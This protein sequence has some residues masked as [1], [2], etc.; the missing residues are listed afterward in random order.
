[1]SRWTR[2]LTL[3][4]P[5]LIILLLV[6]G[7]AA[8]VLLSATTAHLSSPMIVASLGA[9]LVVVLASFAR[10]TYNGL[11]FLAFALASTVF[12][13][14]DPTDLLLVLLL[15]T[16]I[17]LGQVRLSNSQ[18]TGPFNLLVSIFVF[19]YLV[20]VLAGSAVLGEVDLRFVANLVVK[21]VTLYLLKMYIDSPTRSR[22]VLFGYATA[23]LIVS[24]LAWVASQGWLAWSPALPTP[25]TRFQALLADP[26]VFGSF[27]VP[28]FLLLFDDLVKP[29]V[30]RSTALKFLLLAVFEFSIVFSGSR[31]AWLNTGVALCIYALL[32]ARRFRLQRLVFAGLVVI[33]VGLLSLNAPNL[34]G[35]LASPSARVG[36]MPYDVERFHYQA[37]GLEM[38]LGAFFGVG[39]GQGAAVMG[40]APHNFFVQLILE[41]GV[42]TFA[43]MVAL[44]AYSLG[45]LLHRVALRRDNSLGPSYEALIASLCGLIANGLFIDILYWRVLWVL[46]GLV[47]VMAW[48]SF[49]R[50]EQPCESPPRELAP[51]MTGPA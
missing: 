30:W 44:L 3:T 17:A 26:N 22:C 18:V 14:P 28:L 13:R 39:P 8:G 11:V 23:G 41:N 37:R 49:R 50:R 40:Y 46:L 9:L 1:M 15:F 16:G 12:L 27:F 36:L 6:A 20:S 21:L 42:L 5:G 48:P 32:A 7:L 29:A 43:A 33:V 51:R 31:A 45:G 10:S 35:H 24:V 19:F 34:F 4:D 25:D 47:W 38:G 2:V